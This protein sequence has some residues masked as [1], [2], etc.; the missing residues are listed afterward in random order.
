VNSFVA[1]EIL[2]TWNDRDKLLIALN[3]LVDLHKSQSQM[4]M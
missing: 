2:S 3:V 4:S 1:P